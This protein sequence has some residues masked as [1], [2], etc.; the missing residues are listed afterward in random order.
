MLMMINDDYDDDYGDV[1]VCVVAIMLN[2]PDSL[3]GP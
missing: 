3:P 2:H 1:V